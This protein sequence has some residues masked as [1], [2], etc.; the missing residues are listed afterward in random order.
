MLCV[1]FGALFLCGKFKVACNDRSSFCFGRRR[2]RLVCVTRRNISEFKKV[3]TQVGEIGRRGRVILLEKKRP[4]RQKQTEP[5][6]MVTNRGS[7]LHRHG[8]FGGFFIWCQGRGSGIYFLQ[9]IKLNGPV[10]KWDEALSINV[11]L[12]LPFSRVCQQNATREE[13]EGNK[14]VSWPI[15]QGLCDSGKKAKKRKCCRWHFL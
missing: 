9:K 8:R 6:F 10:G 13:R 12:L 4:Y 15:N 1:L 14:L 11:A 7:V 3:A 5:T 2:R